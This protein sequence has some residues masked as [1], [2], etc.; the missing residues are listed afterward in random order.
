MGGGG[1][2]PSWALETWTAGASG[3]R[4]L[5]FRLGQL[6]GPGWVVLLEGPLGA[7]KT[8]LAQGLLAGMGVT[9]RAASPTFTLVY[10]HHG[11]VRVRHADLYRLEGPGEFEAIGGDEMLSDETGVVVVEWADRLGEAAPGQGLWISIDFAG[12]GHPDRRRLRLVFS[13]DLYLPAAGLLGARA[14]ETSR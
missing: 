12:P 4:E 3:T 10:E 13:G 14:E 1:A 11:R 9:G 8:V 6:A 5:G 2:R 7:G